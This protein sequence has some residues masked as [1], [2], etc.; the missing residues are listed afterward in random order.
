MT[1][2]PSGTRRNAVNGRTLTGHAKP[3]IAPPTPAR[4][5]VKDFEA[6]A[7]SVKLDLMPWQRTAGRYLYATGPDAR[8]LYP[9][10]AVVV[11]RQNGKTELLIPFVMDRLERGR[12]IGH[13]AQT[14]ELPRKLFNRLIGPVRAKWPDAIIRKGAGQE[15]IEVPTGG[16]YQVFAATGGAPRGTTID[17]L[18]V[19]EVR[20]VDEDFV[21]AA[22]PTTVASDNPQIVYL[23]NAG[24]EHSLALNSIRMRADADPALAYLE[25][26]AASDRAADD[27]TGW[28][29]ANP[30]LGRTLKVETIER[31]YR[32]YKLAGNL[33]RFETEH[34][35]R[36]VSTMRERLVDEHSWVLC[37]ADTAVPPAPCLAVS[38][39]PQGRRASVAIAGLRSDGSV[40]LR[41][42]FNVTG[43]PINTADLGNDIAKVAGKL[44]V[45]RIG[46]DPL[47]DRE[48]VKFLRLPKPEP[49]SGQLFANA[50]A[51]FVNLVGAGRLQHA[52]CD[53]VTDDLTWTSRKA[54]TDTGTY[55]A[56]RA[57]DDRP[58]TASLAAIRAVWLASGPAPAK[59]RVM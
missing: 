57:Q 47:T 21:G 20:E 51:Q 49:I 2:L 3:R 37:H 18:I 22:G 32:S 7:D 50:S 9:E 42:L 12:A 19:D 58:I 15:T 27:R 59:A 35:C 39:D 25:W 43:D 30:A 34:L 36:W 48:L 40:A 44:K 26:S 13:A 23:S 41:L 29:E 31:F 52:E 45:K 33:G 38:M 16:S 55:Q 14:R 11:A 4:S 5:L 17:D 24:E 56:V 28:A 10:V 8:W 53:P 1:G 6:A 46:F 54:D